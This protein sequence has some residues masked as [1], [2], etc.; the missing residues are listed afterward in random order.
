MKKNLDKSLILKD[1]KT[2]GFAIIEDFYDLVD[3][4]FI[5]DS[6]LQTLNYISESDE[7]DLQK[8]YYEIKKISKKLKSNFYDITPFNINLLKMIHNDTILDFVKF[9]FNTKVVFSGRPA[10]HVHDSDNDRLLMPH[11]ETNQLAR[12][13][14]LFWCPLWD[15]NEET[16]GLTV[17][18]GSHKKGYLEHSLEHPELGNKAWTKN[19]TH[20]KD[21][22]LK[23][24]KKINLSVK[25]G[26]VVLCHSALVH[27]GYPLKN[28]DSVR[29]VITERFNPLDKIPF[30]KKEDASMKIPYV[31]VDY[32]KII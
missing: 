8:K 27:C 11:Q 15:T 30:L 9:F 24:F 28:K 26:S 7:T 13:I 3:L 1:I 14:L 32:N 21:H 31:G 20:I 23:A 5:K 19:Y 17:F 16:G 18:P 25:A 29:I 12:D 10:I 2:S 4:G 22:H 6:L